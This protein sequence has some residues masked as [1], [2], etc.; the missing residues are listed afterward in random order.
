MG[1][2]NKIYKWADL[3]W[4]VSL[5]FNSGPYAKAL[6]PNQKCN[7]ELKKSGGYRN[8]P[9]FIY[10][11]VKC[12]YRVT[13]RKP[14]DDL[15]NDF[16]QIYESLQYKDAEIIN[17]DGDLIKIQRDFQKD[18]DYWVDVK[19]SKNKKGQLQ[20][21]VLAGSK[22]DGDKAQLFLDPAN[23]RLAFDQNNNH[24]TQIFTKVIAI[25]KK[26]TTEM[27]SQDSMLVNDIS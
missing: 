11:C 15:A 10:I 8:T 25:F 3:H 19:L 20:L 4:A 14:L 9:P 5:E 12:N 2:E 18:D 7:C 23:E 21:M 24:P 6:C 16:I 26:S 27:N 17:I 1:E 13:L 22:K